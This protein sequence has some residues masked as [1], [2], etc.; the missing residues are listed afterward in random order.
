MTKD[1]NFFLIIGHF[2][3]LVH[4]EILSRYPNIDGSQWL[5]KD[6]QWIINKIFREKNYGLNGFNTFFLHFSTDFLVFACICFFHSHK[7]YCDV[8]LVTYA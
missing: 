6:V 5:N 4:I 1:F 2:L 7:P 3:S 8:L